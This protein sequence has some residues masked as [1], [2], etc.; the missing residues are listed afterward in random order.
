[1]AQNKYQKARDDINALLTPAP[2]SEIKS[3]SPS[4]GRVN[5]DI[6]KSDNPH[7]DKPS[8][9]PLLLKANQRVPANWNITIAEQG[10]YAECGDLKFKGTREEFNKMLKSGMM[11]KLWLPRLV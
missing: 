9:K 11:E 6:I 2:A 3:D 8:N 5:T 7:V 1:M 10:I 4:V